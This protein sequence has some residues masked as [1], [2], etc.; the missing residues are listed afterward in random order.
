MKLLLKVFVHRTILSGSRFTQK[1]RY[2][3][4]TFNVVGNLLILCN[5]KDRCIFNCRLTLENDLPVQPCSWGCCRKRRRCRTWLCCRWF[6]PSSWWRRCRLRI[7]EGLDRVGSTWCGWAVPSTR[8]SSSCP[9]LARL[10]KIMK[11]WMKKMDE[12][13]FNIHNYYDS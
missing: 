13:H 5:T 3:I 11:N 4:F 9:G 2:R 7:C 6:C 12:S 1:L 8:Q 10:N